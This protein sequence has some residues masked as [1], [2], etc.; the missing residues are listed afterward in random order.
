MFLDPTKLFVYNLYK[1][2]TVQVFGP[3][4]TQ[5][6]LSRLVKMNTT[7]VREIP[8]KF[9]ETGDRKSRKGMRQLKNIEK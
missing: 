3:I 5:N 1:C 6:A 7:E 4:P 8:F 9:E 2:Q